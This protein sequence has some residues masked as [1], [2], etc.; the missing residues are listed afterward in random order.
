MN[1]Y[2]VKS[3]N[4]QRN[5]SRL[6][7][8]YACTMYRYVTLYHYVTLNRYITIYRLVTINRCF[9]IY[10]IVTIYRFVTINRNIYLQKI[11]IRSICRF[12]DVPEEQ[13]VLHVAENVH[14]EKIYDDLCSLKHSA[15]SQVQ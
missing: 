2:Q 15:W 9:A 10:R 5:F 11:E 12:N 13:E 14:E 8:K 3:K 7:H 6:I 1:F 4:L